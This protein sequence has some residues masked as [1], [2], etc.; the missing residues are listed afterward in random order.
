MVRVATPAPAAWLAVWLAATGFMATTDSY[1]ANAAPATAAPPAAATALPA[2]LR[3][4]DG[5]TLDLASLLARGPVLFDFWATWCKPCVVSL[6]EIEALHQRFRA[7]G[8]AVIGVSID[9][10]RNQARV[11]PFVKQLGLTYPIVF[12]GDGRLQERF[13][14]R[15][16]PTALVLDRSG[17]VV[18]FHEGYR[19][20]EGDRLAAQV[21]ALVEPDS[22]NPGATGR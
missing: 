16:V 11:R 21:K 7:Q 6:P 13:N 22:T 2:T 12:D 8:V 10:P 3:T 18:A 20:G 19:P 1:R 14:V 17:K 9:G 4:V 15:A 5:R